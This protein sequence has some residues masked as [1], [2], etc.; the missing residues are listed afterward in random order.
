VRQ[1]SIT[2]LIWF[3][4]WISATGCST[5]QLTDLPLLTWVPGHGNA[6][7]E[8]KPELAEQFN[9]P[10]ES[11]A[12]FSMPHQFPKESLNTGPVKRFTTPMQSAG[13]GMRGP[14]RMGMNGMGGGY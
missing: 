4:A 13:A 7:G 14:G 9:L 10:P 1:L 3:I 8:L 6:G 5:T 11:D 12:R 2:M